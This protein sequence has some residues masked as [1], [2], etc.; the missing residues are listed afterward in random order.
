MGLAFDTSNKIFFFMGVVLELWFI[1]MYAL[2]YGYKFI[3]TG[4][5]NAQELSY[6]FLSMQGFLLVLFLL[7]LFFLGSLIQ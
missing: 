1:L 6:G 2:D 7:L 5:T 3:A 4:A